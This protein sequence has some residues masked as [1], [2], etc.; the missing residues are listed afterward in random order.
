MLKNIFFK[1]F[2]SFK[3]ATLPL[4][5]FT[6]LIGTN[7][8]GKSNA[9]EGMLLLNQIAEGRNQAAPKDYSQN[10]RG[11]INHLGY[12]GESRFAVGCS[13]DEWS[14]T[15][16]LKTKNDGLQIVNESLEI[17]DKTNYPNKTYIKELN[18]I[19]FLS[20]VPRLMR[21]PS[22]KSEKSIHANCRNL[23]GVTYN[24]CRNQNSQTQIL[25]IL[26]RILGINA[27]AIEFQETDREMVTLKL[28]ES[29]GDKVKKWEASLLSDG[30]LRILAIIAALLSAPAG[31]LVVIKNITE[32][33]HPS[34]VKYL[35]EE[36][37]SIALERELQVLISTHNSTLMDTVPPELL[38]DTV[39][40]YRDAEDGSSKLIKLSD[41]SDFPALLARGSLGKLAT[42]QLL[43]KAAKS[44]LTPEEKKLKALKWIN[45]LQQ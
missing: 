29:F 8:S 17:I 11:Q 33:I 26:Q 14:L 24:I 15:L 28:V 37:Y 27:K 3:Q 22:A 41:L 40:C 20:P 19:L 32:R 2:K 1:N 36:M 4:A 5:P 25:S 38:G 31:T 45:R 10:I 6:V 18:D 34:G 30:T 39:L 12:C 42:K 13:K 7:A 21:A 44:V 35:L 43:E 16:E 23:S 9:I